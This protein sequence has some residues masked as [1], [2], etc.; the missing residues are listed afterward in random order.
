MDAW[1]DQP[2]LWHIAISHYSEKARWALEYKS[3]E[4]ERRTAPPGLH[5]A[6]AL[7]LSG[8]RAFT[9]PILELDG[10][11][12]ADSTAIIA[13]LEQRFPEP[14]LYP[15]DPEEHR[16]ALELEEF[17]DEELG[18]YARRLPFHETRRDPELLDQITARVT[19][20]LHARL[21]RALLPYCRA[22]TAVRYRAASSHAAETA[23]QKIIAAIDRLDTELR[24]HDYLVGDRF[25]VA[26]LTAAAL[27]YPIVRPPEAPAVTDRMPE[28]FEHFRDTLRERPG[29]RWVAEIYRRH[30]NTQPPSLLPASQQTAT[31]AA[32]SG[33]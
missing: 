9:F 24:G 31:C 23:R 4:H 5:I 32:V 1:Q 17:F 28:P 3:V 2:T 27:L 14:P 21:G 11:R 16:R 7:W 19:P 18:P 15:A 6:V 13:A 20:K 26:D 29:Y 30:R 22:F 8:G 10:R 25:T 12:I 33:R